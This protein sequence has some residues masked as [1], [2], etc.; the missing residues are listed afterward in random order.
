MRA[1]SRRKEGGG[2]DTAAAWNSAYTCHPAQLRARVAEDTSPRRGKR[3]RGRVIDPD[4]NRGRTTS[5][6]RDSFYG[7]ISAPTSNM[8]APSNASRGIRRS[9]DTDVGSRRLYPREERGNLFLSEIDINESRFPR[10]DILQSMKYIYIYILDIEDRD[11]ITWN[12]IPDEDNS[13]N[14][15]LADDS[16]N[17]GVGFGALREMGIVV[18]KLAR[19]D[20]LITRCG[21]FATTRRRR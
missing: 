1:R 9:I 4:T 14:L 19:N 5:E 18:A 2:D 7:K 3:I 21:S 17:N 11:G 12:L 15:P 8:R 6:R 20:A 10:Q 16:A 13:V